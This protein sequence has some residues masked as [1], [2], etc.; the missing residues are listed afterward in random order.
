MNILASSPYRLSLVTAAV[1]AATILALGLGCNLLLRAAAPSS[2]EGRFRLP[3]R[4]EVQAFKGNN[5]WQKAQFEQD[6]SNHETA[7]VICDMWDRHWCTGAT[8]RVGEIAR[9]MDP[10]LQTARS[11]GILIIH[12]PSD[13]MK[14][15]KDYPQRRMM[16][17]VPHATPPPS[18]GLTSPALPIGDSD[19][20][21]DTPGD[22]EH[23]AWTRENP[24]LSMEPDDAISENGGEIYA[25]LQQR[26]IKNLFIMG[27]HAN[28]C[29]LNRTF[30][31]KQM[32]NWGISCVLVR[33][34][35]DAMYNPRSR[36]Y[37]S[38]AEGTELV[39]GYIE[40]YWCPTTLSA[41]LVKALK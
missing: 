14:F 8:G 10:V 9:K 32:T 4:T 20:G 2:S 18:L 30:A 26:G 12:A 21:C 17:A 37:V 25:L 33:D 6:F 28:M 19:E 23:I 16:L 11:A 13:T 22:T 24:L 35:T 5:I 3:L 40:R 41:D 15:Y 36:P 7:V 27:V 29:I 39:I 38:H 31:I 1:S 34:L